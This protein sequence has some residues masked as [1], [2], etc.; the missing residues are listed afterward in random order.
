VLVEAV[1]KALFFNTKTC[2]VCRYVNEKLNLNDRSWICPK[3]NT[4]HKRYINASIKICRVWASTL[5]IDG[6]SLAIF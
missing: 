1:Y 5:G 6:I 3:C 4:K 2:S